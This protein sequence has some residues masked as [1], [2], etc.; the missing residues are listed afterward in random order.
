MDVGRR[1][2]L[3]L[4]DRLGWR[5]IDGHLDSRE[6]FDGEQRGDSPGERAGELDLGATD[7]DSRAIAVVAHAQLAQPESAAKALNVAV[8]DPIEVS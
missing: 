4:R 8:G 5:A 6:S 3:R 7:L 2:P 1:D